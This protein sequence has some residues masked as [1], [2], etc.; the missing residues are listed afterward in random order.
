LTDAWQNLYQI[1]WKICYLW[2][3]NLPFFG[4]LLCP[5]YFLN[6]QVVLLIAWLFLAEGMG[7]GKVFKKKIKKNSSPSFLCSKY[8]EV[9]WVEKHYLWLIV[10]VIHYPQLRLTY[11]SFFDFSNKLS[12][13]QLTWCAHSSMG[14]EILPLYIKYHL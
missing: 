1:T 14:M 7:K 9:W 6:L 12:V 10:S 2:W 5:L 3:H 8:S 13:H 11:Y 4:I